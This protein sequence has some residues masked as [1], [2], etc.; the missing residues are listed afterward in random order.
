MPLACK[1]N[2]LPSELHPHTN[3]K[4]KAGCEGSRGREA[5]SF[6]YKNKYYHE[7][8]PGHSSTSLPQV[9][10]KSPPAYT[11]HS[12]ISESSGYSY[13]LYIYIFVEYR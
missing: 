1:A 4:G 6:Q 2:A 9:D 13:I 5:K 12:D 11:L 10:K 7:V 3:K 8:A